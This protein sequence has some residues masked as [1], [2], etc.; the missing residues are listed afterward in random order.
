MTIHRLPT[1]VCPSADETLLLRAALLRGGPAREAWEAWEA[2]KTTTPTGALSQTTRHLLP[3]LYL[4]VSRH[5]VQDDRLAGARAAYLETW[6]VNRGVLAAAED[7]L[8][9]L[10]RAGIDA[11]VFKGAALGPLYYRDAGARPVGDADILVRE[12]QFRHATDTLAAAGLAPNFPAGTPDFGIEHAVTYEQVGGHAA[13]DVHCHALAADCAPG[14]D[15]RYWDAAVP[16]RIGRTATR[17]LC[18]TDHLVVA[19]VHGLLFTGQRDLRWIADAVTIIGSD[20]DAVDW[21]RVVTIGRERGLAIQ[22]AAALRYLR[23]R[24][25]QPVPADTLAR[26]DSTR[27]SVG[28]RVLARVLMSPS[29]ERMR[30]RLMFHWARLAKAASP[31]GS[32]SLAGGLARAI[33]LRYDDPHPWRR[34]IVLIAHAVRARLFT[35]KRRS[36]S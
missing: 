5:G 27:T 29:R 23:E 33:T 1:H 4:N 21:D 28:A 16:A 9:R 14:S 19:C 7:A 30:M 22:L 36:G 2:W 10:E 31:D 13:V 11:L 17:T 20:P 8:A 26:L 3:L 32:V 34:S 6:A 15:R 35:P 12:D 24:F 18:L 25:D